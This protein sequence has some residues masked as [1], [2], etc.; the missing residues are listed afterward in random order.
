[1]EK[2]QLMQ[3]NQLL[4]TD[5]SKGLRIY[6]FTGYVLLICFLLFRVGL[7]FSYDPEIG[8]IDNNFVYTVTRML[9]GYSMYT[10]PEEFP[11]AINLYPPLYFDLCYL[12]GKVF[13]V[14]ADNAV[15]VYRLCR[16][17]SFLCDAGTVTFLFFILRRNLFVRKELAMLIAGLFSCLLAYL[18]YTFS[19]CDSLFLFIYA[20]SFF[21]L[22]SAGSWRIRVVILLSILCVACIFSKQ[23][24]VLLPAICF[25]WLWMQGDKKSLAIFTLSTILIFSAVLGLYCFAYGNEIFFANIVKALQNKISWSWFYAYIFKSLVDSLLI[26][27]LLIAISFS[28]LKVKNWKNNPLPAIFLIQFFFSLVSALKWGSSL[29]Y[30]NESF[31]LV[32]LVL[33]G[34]LKNF[35][36]KSFLHKSGIYTLPFVALFALFV[37]SQGYLFFLSQQKAK[38]QEYQNEVQIRE[39]LQPR[40]KQQFV[41]NLS[42]ANRT[43]FK[44]LFYREMAVPNF[45]MVDC[46]TLPDKNFSYQRLEQGFQ[47]GTIQFIIVY[48][49][50]EHKDIWGFSLANYSKD[51]TIHQYDIYQH[52]K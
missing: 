48:K 13:Q 32:P 26:I 21:L 51:T 38:R 17:V 3:S 22:T 1:M 37:Y 25:L 29:G 11:F 40:M 23:N 28:V 19:R 44:N 50:V 49:D 30:F 12:T 18:G 15:A 10:N 24:G 34:P 31:F 33:A 41:F 36:E 39:Y 20:A 43:F 52:K 4:N 7:V 8:G 46:C 35:E 6:L 27:P 42:N 47:D 9:G 2:E 45:D 16:S 14:N 5:N